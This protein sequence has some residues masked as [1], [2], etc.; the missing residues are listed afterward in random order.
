M[1][2]TNQCI[3]VNSFA[4]LDIAPAF[5]SCNVPIVFCADVCLLGVCVKSFFSITDLAT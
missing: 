1:N 5:D 3:D 4:Y 2:D